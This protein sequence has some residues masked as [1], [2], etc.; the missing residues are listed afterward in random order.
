MQFIDS[1]D[2]FEYLS[3]EVAM[4]EIGS[5]GSDNENDMNNDDDDDNEDD[6]PHKSNGKPDESHA[7]TDY[8]RRTNDDELEQLARINA[9][10]NVN[11]SAEKPLKPKGNAVQSS[12][13]ALAVSRRSPSRHTAYVSSNSPRS[14]RTGHATRLILEHETVRYFLVYH[15]LLNIG[16]TEAPSL[17]RY[18]HEKHSQSS[19]S[20]IRAEANI[21]HGE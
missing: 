12:F 21:R 15:L 7:K 18:S 9:T 19:P 4:A 1:V 3:F 17:F 13:I 14:I 20:Q 16:S 8:G 11:P 2:I 5:A 10:Y 6:S